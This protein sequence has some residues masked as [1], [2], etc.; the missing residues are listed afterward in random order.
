MEYWD[1]ESQIVLLLFLKIEGQTLGMLRNDIAKLFGDGRVAVTQ[2][3][4]S[5][6]SDGIVCTLH[7]RCIGIGIDIGFGFGF[8]FGFGIGYWVLVLRVESKQCWDR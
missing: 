5:T 7:R 2:T 8:G 6:K 3:S 1:I 4:E